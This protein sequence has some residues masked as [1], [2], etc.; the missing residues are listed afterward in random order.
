MR[1]ILSSLLI[2]TLFGAG[3]AVSRMMDPAKVIGF[4][5]VAGDWD[6][7]LA[8]VM[9]GALIAAA[10]GFAIARRRRAPV[11]G[12]EFQIPRRNDVDAPLL[13]GAALFGI[14]WGLSGFCPGPALSAL[15]TGMWPVYG[16]VAAMVVGMWT[17]RALTSGRSQLKPA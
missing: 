7:T 8:L 9:I 17:H 1:A 15:A 5:D 3:L 16:F 4:L 14:G 11:L 10:S 2:G 6:P 13:G 12:G